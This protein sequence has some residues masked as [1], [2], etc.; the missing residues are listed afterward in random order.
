[1]QAFK[2]FFSVLSRVKP[3]PKASSKEAQAMWK[4]VLSCR[5]TFLCRSTLTETLCHTRERARQRSFVEK[6]RWTDRLLHKDSLS[7]RRMQSYAF[8]SFL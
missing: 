8:V 7:G 2:S 4:Y 3:L 5:R 6:C 1:M